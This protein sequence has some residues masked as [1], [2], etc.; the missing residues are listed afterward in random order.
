MAKHTT[1][2]IVRQHRPWKALIA[3]VVLLVAYAGS[4]YW[5]FQHAQERAGFDRLSAI[6]ERNRL[7]NRIKELEEANE[8]LTTKLAVLERASQ[9]DRESRAKVRGE[10]K[11]LQDENLELK[12]ELAFY[13]GIVSPEDRKAGLKIQSFE[14]TSGQEP[15]LYMYKLILTQVLKNDRLASGTVAIEVE[16]VEGGNKVRLPL[17]RL[18]EGAKETLPFRFKFF[19]NFEGELRLPPGFNAEAV[20]LTVVPTTKGLEKLEQ[21][22][23]WPITNS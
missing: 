15:S 19:Q 14:I 11:E 10:V 13:R 12:Q 6:K 3:A 9:I 22:V 7:E 8:Q 21:R 5:L 18:A 2:F 23:P 20:V 4:S 1:T 17:S 16:G